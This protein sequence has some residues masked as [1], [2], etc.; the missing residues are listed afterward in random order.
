MSKPVP[1]DYPRSLSKEVAQWWA[2]FTVKQNDFIPD[3]IWGKGYYTVFKHEA[4]D[5]YM[6]VTSD[7]TVRFIRFGD[8]L[9]EE[10]GGNYVLY[11]S[12]GLTENSDE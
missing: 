7:S 6:Y 4:E 1:K 8:T 9:S 10:R 11:L 2:S 3:P 5:T 12:S